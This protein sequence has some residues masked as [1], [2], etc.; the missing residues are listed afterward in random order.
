LCGA[1]THD[2]LCC[3][4]CDA[5]LPRLTEEHCPTCALP[6]LASSVCGRCLKQPPPFDHTVAAFSYQFPLDKLIQAL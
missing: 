4:A 1:N 2:G 5:D 3:A 6:A